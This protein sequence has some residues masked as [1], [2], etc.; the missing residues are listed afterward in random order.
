MQLESKSFLLLFITERIFRD[1]EGHEGVMIRSLRK[2]FGNGNDESS[3]IAVKDLSLNLYN[4][5][6]FALLGIFLSCR[7]L[8]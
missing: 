2:E 3:I 6:I 7:I 5:Q 1:L 8:Q 4:G